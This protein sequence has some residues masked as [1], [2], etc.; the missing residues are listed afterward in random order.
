MVVLVSGFA[1][2]RT[3][4]QFEWTWQHGDTSLD[5]REAMKRLHGMIQDRFGGHQ[6]RKLKINGVVGQF[7]RL[8]AILSTPPWKYFP[9]SVRVAC[10]S[11]LRLVG[12][13]VKALVDSM[14]DEDSFLSFPEHIDISVGPLDEFM[15]QYGAVDGGQCPISHDDGV[16]DEIEESRRSSTPS[17]EKMGKK[18]MKIRCLICHELAQRTWWECLS[19]GGRVHVGC[20]AEHFLCSESISRPE[21][22]NQG[23]LLSLPKQASC[24]PNRGDCPHCGMEVSWSE[25][26]GCLKTAGWRKNKPNGTNSSGEENHINMKDLEFKRYSTSLNTGRVVDCK[27]S[28]ICSETTNDLRLDQEE[29]S[30]TIDSIVRMT[31]LL[32]VNGLESGEEDSLASRCLQRLQE[33]HEQHEQHEQQKPRVA[34]HALDFDAVESDSPDVIDLCSSEDEEPINLTGPDPL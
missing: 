15:E 2:Q 18:N 1:N 21:K 10:G 7:L 3:A 20:L 13:A 28:V 33:H 17:P 25:V 5:T 32:S 9:L 6:K 24:L 19:C 27:K 30:S 12:D 26:L 22:M 31:R 34:R 8:V 16:L 4:L 29:G 11:L 14:P 23:F